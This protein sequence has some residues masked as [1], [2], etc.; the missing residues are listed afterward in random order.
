MPDAAGQPRAG[1]L[2]Q[3]LRAQGIRDARVLAA[4]DRVPRR[5][6]V[7]PELRDEAEDDR[8]LDIGLGQTIS[9]P[10]IVAAMTQALELRGDERVLEVGTGSG[11][12]TALLAELLPAPAVVRS[13]EVRPELLQRAR[14]T[15]ARLG[16]TNVELRLGDG[17]LGWPEAAPFAGILVAAAPAR[18][19]EALFAQL[20]P[21]GRLVIP[22]GE[23]V[24][25]QELEL[26]RKDGGGG[27]A[28]REVLMPVRFVP[29]V[30]PR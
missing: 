12:Q 29:L 19:P 17:R 25:R 22:V 24:E 7:P 5:A 21:G 3:R 2:S 4:F 6:F 16:Y 18:V 23:D 10:F 11:Y 26:W 28:R 27:K 14:Q 9:Q 20:A 13:I 15:L 30:S 1:A 8:A